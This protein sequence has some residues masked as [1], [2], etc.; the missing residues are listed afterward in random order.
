M[1]SRPRPAAL[2]SM[3]GI[4]HF[5]AL[6]SDLQLERFLKISEDHSLQPLTLNSSMNKQLTYT[7]PVARLTVQARV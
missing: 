7:I 6:S 2:L 3:L 5:D 1:R 4:M